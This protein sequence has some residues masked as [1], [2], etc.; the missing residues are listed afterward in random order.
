VGNR[1]CYQGLSCSRWTI[2]QDPLRGFHPDPCEDLGLGE[3]I[4]HRFP[5]L[6]DLLLESPNM[7]KGHVRRFLKLH[8]PDPGV[9]NVPDNTDDREC[10]VDR[11]LGPR[12]ELAEELIVHMRDVF[13]V[14]PLLPEVYLAFSQKIDHYGD[15]KGHPLE[16]I[17]LPLELGIVPGQLIVPYLEV[18]EL[19]LEVL[20]LQLPAEFRL[21]RWGEDGFFHY[22]IIFGFLPFIRCD[23]DSP[24]AR[25]ITGERDRRAPR[26][27]CC[28]LLPL[29]S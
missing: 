2:E 16:L 28:H 18:K 7:I 12:L 5:H 19:G 11:D 23:F 26:Q 9:K 20:C 8:H 4:L 14:I 22:T 3:R 15:K 6:L 21:T 1:L 29:R 10:V 13:L 27:S 17:V 25:D 24:W